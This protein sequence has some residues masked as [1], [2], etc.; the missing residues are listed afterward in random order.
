MKWLKLHDMSIAILATI[1][2]ALK[3]LIYCFSTDKNMLYTV[4]GGALFDDLFTQPLRSTMTQIVGPSDVGKVSLRTIDV[5]LVFKTNMIIRCL[6]QLDLFRLWWDLHLQ[7]S[8]WFISTHWVLTL[9]WSTLLFVVLL[10]FSWP[11]WFILWPSS[12]AVLTVK[13]N[14]LTVNFEGC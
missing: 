6:Q 4:L 11:C 7:F 2:R 1:C 9:A 12:N 3:C 10:L 13:K 5:Y 14:T 8:T